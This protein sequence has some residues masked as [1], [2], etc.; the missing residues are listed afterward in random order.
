MPNSLPSIRSLVGKAMREVSDLT[1]FCMSEPAPTGSAVYTVGSVATVS[2]DIKGHVD[3]NVGISR[4]MAMLQRATEVVNNQKKVMA[5][6]DYQDKLSD[7]VKERR[8]EESAGEGN[9]SW[10]PSAQHRTV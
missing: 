9:G 8:Q 5:V 3:I 1:I 4:A 7:A 10:E 6:P 2:S